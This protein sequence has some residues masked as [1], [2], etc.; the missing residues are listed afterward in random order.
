MRDTDWDRRGTRDA[1]RSQRLSV[2]TSPP[3]SPSS[4]VDPFIPSSS[5]T[6]ALKRLKLELIDLGRDP[7]PCCS[8]GPIGDNPLQWQGVI[9][10]ADDSPYA[11][12]VFLLSITFPTNYPFKPPVVS[13]TTKIYHPNIDVDG[14]I[15]LD[16]LQGQW[17]PVL[18]ISTV[19]LSICSLLT[20]PNVDDPVAPDIAYLYKT[21]RAKYD[22]TAREWTRKYAI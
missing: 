2:L 1:T 19:L 20:D 13:F 10:G 11:G 17:S 16:I 7:P 22:A 18:T 12:G 15:W 14:Y 3:L 4:F 6:T 5:L 9:F 21:D 8:A